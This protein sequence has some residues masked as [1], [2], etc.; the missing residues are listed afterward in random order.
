MSV[1]LCEVLKKLFPASEA[2]AIT[3]G[4]LGSCLLAVISPGKGSLMEA[5]RPERVVVEMALKT[6][7]H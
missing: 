3:A 4:S 7:Q 2:A 6:E 5:W 1:L